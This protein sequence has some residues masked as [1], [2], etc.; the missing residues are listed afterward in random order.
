MDLQLESEKFLK[1]LKDIQLKNDLIVERAY[2]SIQLCRNTLYI[3]KKE[4]VSKGFESIESEINFFKVTKQIPL[5]Q[6]IYFS[7]IHSFEIQ[8]PKAD[9]NYQLKFIKKKIHKLN[10]FFLQNLDFDKYANSRALYFDKEYYTRDYMGS[11]HLNI[12]KFYFQDPDFSTPRDMLL[13]QLKANN[14]LVNYLEERLFKLKNNLNGNRINLHP[15]EKIPWPFSNADWVELVYALWAVGLKKQK[16]LS[17]IQVSQKLQEVFDYEPK[18][19]YKGYRYMKNRKISRTIFLD[20]MATSLLFE[21][22]KSEE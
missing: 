3:Y 20:R 7:E 5:V 4:I 19:I 9:K 12:S 11:Y 21:M 8:F 17:I 22:D 15:T 16:E 10:R 2:R 1:K 18:D 14:S 6:L 13:G